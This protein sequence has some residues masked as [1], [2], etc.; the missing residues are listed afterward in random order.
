MPHPTKALA[1]IAVA[2]VPWL[3]SESSAASQVPEPDVIAFDHSHT[4]WSQ[5]LELFQRED[6]IDYQALQKNREPLDRYLT[7][8]THVTPEQYETWNRNQRFAF[9]INTYN[10]FT[11]H[12]VVQNYPLESIRD[13]GTIFNKVWDKR[14]IP[15][16]RFDPQGKGRNLSLND[17]EHEILR[18]RFEDARVHAAIN[19]A[20][21]GC[22]PMRAGAF[23]AAGLEAEL[24]SQVRA[25][26]ADPERNRFDQAKKTMVVSEIFKWFSE[27]FERDAGSVRDWIV[28]YA[29]PDAAKW[30]RTEKVRRKYVDYD[31]SLNDVE[32]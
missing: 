32:R 30:L 11:V 13:L 5:V 4:Q 14:F 27:D 8:L 24:D 29:P 22:P 16:T 31:W 28:R 26:L 23:S 6:R 10:A 2:L 25:W 7:T 9:W 19:C 15:L 21:I 12:L 17:I 18:P 20:S 1:L 3:F